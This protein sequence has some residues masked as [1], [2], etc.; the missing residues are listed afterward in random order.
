MQ[1][2]DD[3]E[4]TPKAEP[5]E[6]ATDEEMGDEMEIEDAP[7]DAPLRVSREGVAGGLRIEPAD[8][9]PGD[10][11]ERILQILSEQQEKRQSVES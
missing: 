3:Q 11:L 6:E 8:G 9:Q 5:V 1:I 4:V 10:R 2:E 7:E